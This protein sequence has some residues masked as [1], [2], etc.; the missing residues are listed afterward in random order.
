MDPSDTHLGLLAEPEWMVDESAFEDAWDP[1]RPEVRLEGAI[2]RAEVGNR[3]MARAQA[4]VVA[5]VAEAIREARECPELFVP[6]PAAADANEFVVRAVV[7][8]L[9]VRLAVSEPKIR[10]WAH[11]AEVMRSTLPACWARFREGDLSAAHARVVTELAAPLGAAERAEFDSAA[12]GAAE[13]SPA[14]FRARMRALAARLDSAHLAERHARA[15][16]DR[17]VWVEHTADGMAWLSALLPTD[18]AHRVFAAVDQLAGHIVSAEDEPRTRA[19]ARA[20]VLVDLV[21]GRLGSP[22]GT[23]APSDGRSTSVSV[24]VTVPVL[25]LLGVSEEPGTLDGIHPIDAETARRLAAHAPSF[26]R[27]LTHPVSGAVLAVDRGTYRV[28]RDLRR[29]VQALHPTCTF[30][31][32]GRRTR[33]CD[34]DH[35]EPHGR[36]G[37]TSAAN[38]APLCRHHHRVRH[39][40]LWRRDTTPDPIDADPPPPSAARSR[41]PGEQ[42]VWTSPTGHRVLPP[43]RIPPTPIAPP[44]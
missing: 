3:A 32:C 31:G 15:R 9:A 17:R 12:A 24:A 16:D 27:L 10:A 23:G 25:T 29:W 35:I 5:S 41:A 39:R 14:R 8:D 20:D 44:F 22:A 28:P 13:Q 33:D 36:G 7:A 18:D 30:A 19:Q 11:Q 43:P 6:D 4:E 37:P 34:L 2:A 1:R 21:A 26:T 40:T 42:P 38:L